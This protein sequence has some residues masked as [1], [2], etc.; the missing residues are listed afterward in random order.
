MLILYITIDKYN[1][2]NTKGAFSRFNS[3]K[4][5]RHP[6]TLAKFD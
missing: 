1:N 4:F 5:K 3:P 6:I 2:V